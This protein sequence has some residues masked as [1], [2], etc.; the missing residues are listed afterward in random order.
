MRTGM[1]GGIAKAKGRA[2][3]PR[4]SDKGNCMSQG[5][6]ALGVSAPSEAPSVRDGADGASPRP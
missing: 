2:I 3:R 6:A 5:L 1:E 4:C